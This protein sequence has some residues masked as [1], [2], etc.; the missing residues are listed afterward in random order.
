[1]LSRRLVGG[2]PV[3]HVYS[4][5]QPEAG[6]HKIDPNLQDVYFQH[7]NAHKNKAA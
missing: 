2:Q 6:F 1:V 3:I 5:H 7:L 4:E